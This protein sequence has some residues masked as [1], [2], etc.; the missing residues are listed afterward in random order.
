MATAGPRYTRVSSKKWNDRWYLGL[1][2]R[3]RQLFDYLC[4]NGD[5]TSAGVYQFDPD[6]ARMKTRPWRR[7]EFE[8]A[9]VVSLRG[10]IQFYEDSWIWVVRYLHYNGDNMNPDFAT[11]VER[12]VSEAP[13]QLQA[14]FWAAYTK[15]LKRHGVPSKRA[16][17]GLPE[18][19]ETP[20][21]T[22]P[23]PSI[24]LGRRQKAPAEPCVYCRWRSQHKGE[25]IPDGKRFRYQRFHDEG[26]ERLRIGCVPIG[27]KEQ[28][29][30]KRACHKYG[31]AKVFEWWQSFLGE[32][33]KIGHSIAVFAS[34]SNLQQM[35]EKWGNREPERPEL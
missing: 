2:M 23:Y 19:C 15:S 18:P 35:D 25:D 21:L 32:P 17:T 5:N 13:P 6:V 4:E 30:L 31:E 22:S 27:G 12:I 8:E 10:H 1:R 24:P 20:S 28:K 29:L 26:V 14:D 34:A 11:G 7:D 9:C 3:E 33:N 16:L